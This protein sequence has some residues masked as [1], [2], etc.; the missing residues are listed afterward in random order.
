MLLVGV[1][2]C[3]SEQVPGSMSEYVVTP[4]PSQTLELAKFSV[5]NL[6]VTPQIAHS[7]EMITITAEITN[8]GGSA[9][10]YTA[11]LNVANVQKFQQVYVP[12]Q[13]KEYV[14][15]EV[16]GGAG[17]YF[18]SIGEMSANYTVFLPEVSERTPQL[19]EFEK[20]IATGF[21]ILHMGQQLIAQDGTYLGE[22]GSQFASKSIFNDFGKYG[23]E[24]SSTS[25]WNEFSK[26]GSKYSSLSAFNDLA[27]KPPK[28]F[29][30][31]QFVCYV[32][33]NDFKYPNVSPYSLIA[34]AESM[35]W[36]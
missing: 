28:L 34:Y 17:T 20:P 5:T 12:A 26:Y 30:G 7:N 2:S 14:S 9:G 33:T 8:S 35:G 13:S 36:K 16:T 11:T 29:D 21:G 23:S 22:L 24:F 1:V 32:T 31:E 25:I 18:P 19:K 27:N 6:T 3:D 4:S 15:F 10:Y